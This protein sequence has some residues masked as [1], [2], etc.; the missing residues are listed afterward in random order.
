[1][2]KRSNRRMPVDD[3]TFYLRL[4]ENISILLAVVAMAAFTVMM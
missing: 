3:R 2:L 1:M 4:F